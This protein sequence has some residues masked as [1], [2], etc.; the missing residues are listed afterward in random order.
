MRIVVLQGSPNRD[1]ST[2][3]LVE[4]FARGAR[5]AGHEV[6]RIDV[7][8]EDVAPC[9]GCDPRREQSAAFG[10]VSCG[11]G[12][13]RRRQARRGGKGPARHG[14]LERE[15]EHYCEKGAGK[16]GRHE[17][18]YKT[19]VFAG[20]RRSGCGGSDGRNSLGLRGRL[21]RRGQKLLHRHCVKRRQGAHPQR[22][23]FYPPRGA[24]PRRTIFWNLWPRLPRRFTT[25]WAGTWRSST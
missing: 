19:D 3:M 4:E 17:R 8:H 1:G 7:A 24:A 10:A 21:W 15:S 14:A 22:R 23:R 2:A 11:A 16:R 18:H 13:L 6:V 5:Q 9:A 25:T 12:G 20:C